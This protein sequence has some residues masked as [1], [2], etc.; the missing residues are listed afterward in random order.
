MNCN[1]NF[2]SPIFPNW[3]LRSSKFR[4]QE[5]MSFCNLRLYPNVHML[6]KIGR[7]A[8]VGL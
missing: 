4:K 3:V 8:L 5:L 1:W 2:D 7:K 6:A